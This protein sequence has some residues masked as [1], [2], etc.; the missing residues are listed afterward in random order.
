VK[1]FKND[2]GAES[3]DG[4]SDDFGRKK[5]K[6]RWTLRNVTSLLRKEDINARIGVD[7]GSP[8]YMGKYSSALTK[9]VNKLTAAERGEYLA[10]AEQ[11]N[12]ENPP[13]D[14]QKG[15]V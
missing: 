15:K 8:V 2:A 1:W 10:L 11:W 3:D 13:R 9:V 6:K 5:W 7:P 14:V 4:A 12:R